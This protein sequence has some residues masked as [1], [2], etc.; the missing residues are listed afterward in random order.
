MFQRAPHVCVA[1]NDRKWRITSLA[2]YKT[3]AIEMGPQIL[4]HF[5][6]SSGAAVQSDELVAFL[7]EF[8][9]QGWG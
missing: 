6:N 8:L 4:L 9:Q 7:W 1:F 2:F 5:Q 3:R